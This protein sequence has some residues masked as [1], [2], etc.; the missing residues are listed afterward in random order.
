MRCDWGGKEGPLYWGQ[1]FR[2]STYQQGRDKRVWVKQVVVSSLHFE[3]YSCC[4][5]E[6]DCRGTRDQVQRLQIGC[7]LDLGER[8]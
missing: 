5:L 8:G 1:G 6:K 4:P 3:A 2:R 7:C